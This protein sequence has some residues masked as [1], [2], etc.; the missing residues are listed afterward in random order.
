MTFSTVMILV[1]EGSTMPFLKAKQKL[2]IMH[3]ETKFILAHNITNLL[4]R[5]TASAVKRIRIKNK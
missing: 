5:M 4:K 3:H 2:S 1:P